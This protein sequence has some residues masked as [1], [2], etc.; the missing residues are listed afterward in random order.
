MT[1]VLT[2]YSKIIGKLNYLNLDKLV[3]YLKKEEELIEV[4]LI[5]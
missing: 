5:K 1:V 3:K 2:I 4:A